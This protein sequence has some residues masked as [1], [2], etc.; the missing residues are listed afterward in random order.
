[1]KELL[2]KPID[3]FYVIYKATPAKS[4]LFACTEYQSQYVDYVND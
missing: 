3:Q 1:V 2:Y 4:T